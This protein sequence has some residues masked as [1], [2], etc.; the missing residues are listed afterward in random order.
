L[1]QRDA[2]LKELK[3][4]GQMAMPTARQTAKRAVRKTAA[5]RWQGDGREMA[6]R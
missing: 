4:A 2:L 3:K 6:G 1:Q 5:G